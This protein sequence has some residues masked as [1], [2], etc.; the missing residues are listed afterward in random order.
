MT[1]E[2]SIYHVRIEVPKVDEADLRGAF[3]RPVEVVTKDFEVLA[4]VLS[5]PESVFH[6]ENRFELHRVLDG[7]REALQEIED[8]AIGCLAAV[9]REKRRVEALEERLNGITI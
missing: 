2:R 9:K 8:A 1:T 3:M 5:R 4:H 7:A 6:P